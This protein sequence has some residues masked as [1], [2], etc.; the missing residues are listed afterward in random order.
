MESAAR[1]A[2]ARWLTCPL[3]RA[4]SNAPS[5]RA[6]AAEAVSATEA[7][8]H[9]SARIRAAMRP[10]HWSK[11][12]AAAA[13][14]RG[15]MMGDSS[16]VGAIGQPR[17]ALPGNRSLGDVEEA[18]HAECSIRRSVQR[19]AEG[20][21]DGLAGRLQRG[22]GEFLH[23]PGK[24]VVERPVGHAALRQQLRSA[25]GR[26]SLVTQQPRHRLDQVGPGV[27]VTDHLLTLLERMV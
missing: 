3:T 5:M 25:G 20:V 4:R 13:R 1:L 10:S 21:S 15:L 19:L 9:P 8:G 6:S 12:R 14:R 18:D 27:T 11:H 16:A 17:Q 24:V 23:A 2:L 22:L 7:S 26:I